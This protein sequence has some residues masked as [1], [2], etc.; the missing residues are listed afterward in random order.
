[1][2]K[3]KPGSFA[4]ILRIAKEDKNFFKYREQLVGA[5]IRVNWLS[6]RDGPWVSATG[7]LVLRDVW[8]NENGLKLRKGDHICLHKAFLKVLCI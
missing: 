7:V 3:L 2:R 4:E 5:Q 8:L 1:M 6:S